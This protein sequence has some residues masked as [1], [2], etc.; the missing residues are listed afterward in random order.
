VR[1]LGAAACLTGMGH[2]AQTLVAASRSTAAPMRTLREG[3][4]HCISQSA[5]ARAGAT[6]QGRAM[7]GMSTR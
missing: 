3:L 4:K 5:A 6:G 7:T 1:L 2:L